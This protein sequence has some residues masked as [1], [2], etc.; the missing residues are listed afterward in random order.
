MKNITIDEKTI[1]AKAKSMLLVD[2][3]MNCPPLPFEENR[4]NTV[5]TII[6][7]KKIT[8][9]FPSSIYFVRS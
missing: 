7:P 9:N 6:T 1:I 3:I 5:K 2:G 4:L 8:N